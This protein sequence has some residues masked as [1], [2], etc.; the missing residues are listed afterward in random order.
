MAK[1]DLI[2]FLWWSILLHYKYRGSKIL[3]H[4]FLAFFWK[5]ELENWKIGKLNKKAI[6][7]LFVAFLW[8][9]DSFEGLNAVWNHFWGFKSK[10]W[11]KK[12]IF[13]LW[14]LKDKEKIKL[15]TPN[16]PEMLTKQSW[17]S[18]FLL[19]YDKTLKYRS[20][21]L[22]FGVVI[23]VH[24]SASF[25]IKFLFFFVKY[26]CY[27]GHSIKVWVSGM[28]V[29]YYLHFFLKGGGVGKGLI[30]VWSKFFWM[31]VCWEEKSRIWHV[32]REWRA[33]AQAQTTSTKCLSCTK[34]E[35]TL[36]SRPSTTSRTC[37][38]RWYKND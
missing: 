38:T 29:S 27:L 1:G 23:G 9:G 5:T 12:L 20:P 17:D 34:T 22:F 35:K 33:R 25:L 37:N 26:K 13:E 14:R 15:V 21:A 4:W 8:L 3:A 11:A 24:A 36:R 10:F 6:F 2:F 31:W 30:L 28:C 18:N 16:E 7:W 19:Q 32:V